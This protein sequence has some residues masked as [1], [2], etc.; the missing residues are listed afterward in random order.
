MKILNTIIQLRRDNDY[1][2]DS[3]KDKF[4]PANGE[5]VLVD[6]S[7]TGLRIKIGDGITTYA[8][9]PFADKDARQSV[10]IGYYEDGQFY[11][12]INKATIL[13]GNEEK[14]YIDKSASNV[15]YYNGN[16]Y[17]DLQKSASSQNPG[18]MKLYSTLGNNTDGT[19]TQQ[20][21]TEEFQSRYKISADADKEL[22]ILSI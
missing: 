8:N 9:L 2:F 17:I 5:V 22:L 1:N 4:I 10:I 15:Y 18:I 12:D 11:N 3:I 14:L 21:I 13:S 7:S 6:T 16:A 19:I 20:K